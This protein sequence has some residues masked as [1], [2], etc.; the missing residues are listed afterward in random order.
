MKN[1][2]QIL[3]VEPNAT[4]DDI[5]KS[6]RKLSLKFHPDK[7]PDDKYFEQRFK[8]INEAYSILGNSEKRA[9]YDEEFENFFSE[10]KDF[11]DIADYL[12]KEAE[13]LKREKENFEREK[14]NFKT[15]ESN[16][17]KQESSKNEKA[18]PHSE[19]QQDNSY[20]L[21]SFAFGIVML[22]VILVYYKS[23]LEGNF[24]SEDA[25]FDYFTEYSTKDEVIEN[26]GIPDKK[27]I[28]P[29][30]DTEI[31]YYSRW[32]DIGIK[33]YSTITF[34][35]KGVID[36]DNNNGNFKCKIIDSV[37]LLKE[38]AVNVGMSIFKSDEKFVDTAGISNRKVLLKRG[39]ILLN[40]ENLER[41]LLITPNS[42]VYITHLNDLELNKD[43]INAEYRVAKT[44]HRF[45]GL[46]LKNY[47]E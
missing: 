15:S 7:N 45:K 10:N 22:T 29:S 16:N 38:K 23:N 25:H 46:I 44:N 21:K 1:Y 33:Q 35:N 17:K 39:A 11:Q 3:G 47:L 19:I 41:F 2:Y 37:S 30:Y 31:W 27:S 4:S 9:V 18:N 14:A 13:K 5:K 12:R 40:S 43:F 6:Y 32:W 20:I 24:E 42:Y 36:F 28:F 8:E 26:Q 34:T